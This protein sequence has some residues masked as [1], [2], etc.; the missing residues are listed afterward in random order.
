MKPIEKYRLEYTIGHADGRH[1]GMAYTL[2]ECIALAKFEGHAEWDD[3]VEAYNTGAGISLAIE[4]GD[5]KSFEIAR[6]REIGMLT[7]EEESRIIFE[8]LEKEVAAQ[9]E[10]AAAVSE[11]TCVTE[12][13]YRIVRRALEIVQGIYNNELN[14]EDAQAHAFVAAALLKNVV[15][16]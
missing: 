4:R 13:T 7:N 2:E 8:E 11:V 12:S 14:A 9:E 16:K 5:A 15:T 10:V 1:M 3:E 6:L